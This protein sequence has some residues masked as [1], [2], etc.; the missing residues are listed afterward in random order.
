M[1][2]SKPPPNIWLGWKSDDSGKDSSL[3]GYGNKLWPQDCLPINAFVIYNYVIIV[4]QVMALE[5]SA[6]KRESIEN[7]LIVA[8][9]STKI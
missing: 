2:C 8:K 7:N 6:L 4:S 5:H 1:V 3:I 9:E